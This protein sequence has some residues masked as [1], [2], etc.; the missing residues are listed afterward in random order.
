MNLIYKAVKDQSD[1]NGWASLSLVRKYIANVKPEFD[2]RT[3]G[4]SKISELFKALGVF[5]RRI[6]AA[7]ATV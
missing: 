6:Q 1:D 4:K 5:E 3:Y 7:S 2:P